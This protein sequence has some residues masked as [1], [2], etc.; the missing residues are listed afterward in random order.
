MNTPNHPTCTF[1]TQTSPELASH[2][3]G[4]GVAETPCLPC[5]LPS[6][7][8]I[9]RRLDQTTLEKNPQ[10]EGAGRERTHLS[11]GPVAS[12]RFLFVPFSSSLSPGRVVSSRSPC[13][14]FLPPAPFP[15][16]VLGSYAALAPQ[17]ASKT[18]GTLKKQVAVPAARREQLTGVGRKL[19][20]HHWWGLSCGVGG[21]KSQEGEGDREKAGK[22]TRVPARPG[23]W[24]NVRAVK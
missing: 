19:V 2:G 23:P 18:T 7:S 14:L 4:G 6:P 13:L 8:S 22:G 10:R 24:S 1:R 12:G 9:H 5:R 3:K 17:E 11:A 15:P 20:P 21:G 16:T